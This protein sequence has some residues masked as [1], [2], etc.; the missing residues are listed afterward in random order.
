VNY[1]ALKA[2][3][4][5][6]AGDLKPAYAGM[7]DAQVAAAVTGEVAIRHVDVPIGDVI[8]YLAQR[9]ILVALEDWLATLP[10]PVPANVQVARVAAKELLRLTSSTAITQFRMSDAGVYARIGGML[11]AL[12]ADPPAVITAANK[13]ELLALADELSGWLE[14]NFNPA[15]TAIS[16]ADIALARAA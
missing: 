13:T 3:I 7:T 9:G 5:D 10:S 4:F 16:A 15:I 2:H 6:G 12:I 11:D 8:G 14:V 1:A